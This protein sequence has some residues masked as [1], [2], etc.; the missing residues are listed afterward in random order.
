MDKIRTIRD[1]IT[2]EYKLDGVEAH[3]SESESIWNTLHGFGISK[4]DIMK[5]NL[6]HAELYKIHVAV[7][8]YQDC[9]KVLK[10]LEEY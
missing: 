10:G 6:S 2:Q 4:E 9:Q 3:Q 1:T 8:T 7:K 5:Q